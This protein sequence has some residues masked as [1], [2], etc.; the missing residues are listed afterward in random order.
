MA[1]RNAGSIAVAVSWLQSLKRLVSPTPR[2]VRFNQDLFCDVSGMEEEFTVRVLNLK[3]NMLW[4]EEKLR[5]AA[6]ASAAR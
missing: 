1:A 2:T 3:K 5:P 6:A 4:F